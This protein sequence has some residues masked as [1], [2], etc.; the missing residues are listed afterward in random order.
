[1]IF[2]GHSGDPGDTAGIYGVMREMEQKWRGKARTFGCK[3][4]TIGESLGQDEYGSQFEIRLFR[5]VIFARF[6][7]LSG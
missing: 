2:F 6:R 7:I 4:G 1:M 5:I 3:S